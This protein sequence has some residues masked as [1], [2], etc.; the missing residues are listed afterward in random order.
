M[1][2]EEITEHVAALQADTVPPAEDSLQARVQHGVHM[3]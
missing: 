3:C 1:T 2:L